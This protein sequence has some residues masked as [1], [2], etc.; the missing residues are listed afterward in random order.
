MKVCCGIGEI[1]FDCDFILH[2]AVALTRERKRFLFG[3]E[4]EEYRSNINGNN[5]GG[6]VII[7]CERLRDVSQF[8][9]KY[10][11]QN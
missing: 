9:L 8:F 6:S 7:Q 10:H 3:K 5:S 4:P 2:Y 1:I 11:E